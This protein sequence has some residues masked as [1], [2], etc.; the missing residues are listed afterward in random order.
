MT[1][2][3]F[4]WKIIWNTVRLGKLQ[5][6]IIK[7]W[8]WVFGDITL[9]LQTLET[10]ITWW[11]TNI[12]EETTTKSNLPVKYTVKKQLFYYYYLNKGKSKKW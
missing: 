8:H 12:A 1:R 7:H 2:C 4:W 9:L 5:G 10:N 6:I 3:G 11:N